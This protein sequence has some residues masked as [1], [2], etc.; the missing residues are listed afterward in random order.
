M[1]VKLEHPLD[2]RLGLS[3]DVNW[4]C[5]QDVSSRHPRVGQIGSLREA[6]KVEGGRHGD[7]HLLAGDVLHKVIKLDC[8]VRQ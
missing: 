8:S 4:R 6:L 7:Q 3:Q 5:P 1:N 2:V